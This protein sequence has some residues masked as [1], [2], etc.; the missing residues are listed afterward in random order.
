MQDYFPV[1]VQ[2]IP[3]DNYHVQVFFDNGKIVDYNAT[4]LLQGE[5]FKP[6]QDIQ[7]FKDTCTVLNDTLAWD[8][9]GNRDPSESIDIDPFTLYELDSINH[10]IA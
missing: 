5:V 3:L 4:N 1:V 8:I 10:L 9:S 6:L 7:T 2:V